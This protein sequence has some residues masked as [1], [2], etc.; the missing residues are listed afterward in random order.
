[1]I[2]Q[3]TYDMQFYTEQMED[4]VYVTSLQRTLS[5]APKIDFT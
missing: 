2:L 4:T 3:F 5:N 1:M